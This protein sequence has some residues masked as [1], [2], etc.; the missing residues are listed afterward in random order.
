M[1]DI[2]FLQCFNDLSLTP[3]ASQDEIRNAR[4]V[5]A[6]LYHDDRLRDLPSAARAKAEE[7]LKRANHA[8][9]VLTHP[10]NR[11]ELE[12]W[13]Q[14][15]QRSASPAR[16]A[17]SPARI[18]LGNLR[19]GARKTVVVN[20]RNDGGLTDTLPSITWLPEVD[21]LAV[22]PVSPSDP[23]QY[24]WSLE[25]IATIP[26]DSSRSGRVVVVFT[27]DLEG[28]TARLEVAAALEPAIASTVGVATPLAPTGLGRS[29]A[30]SPPPSTMSPAATTASLRTQIADIEAEIS[31]GWKTIGLSVSGLI[32]ALLLSLVTSAF[33]NLRTDPYHPS[34][35]GCLRMILVP[36]GAIGT[37]IIGLGVY[38]G[39]A[40]IAVMTILQI[41]G[42]VVRRARIANL[43]SRMP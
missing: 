34:A 41:V 27:V 35:G 25:L 28:A 23:S 1:N 4:R 19:P 9:G 33:A 22:C 36:I 42:T 6:H 31:S 40:V 2:D 38:A 43:K 10:D 17:F 24:P 14:A 15:Y 5:L 7:L 3:G 20:I 29:T 26:T 21:W 11:R 30:G 32:G 13:V 8:H 12:E 18:D 16:P 39:A 37:I